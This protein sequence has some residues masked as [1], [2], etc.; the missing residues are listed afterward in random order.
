MRQLMFAVCV[1]VSGVIASA[2][3]DTPP[4]K[5]WVM[6]AQAALDW[7]KTYVNPILNRRVSDPQEIVAVRSRIELFIKLEESKILNYYPVPFYDPKDRTIQGY[8]F[9]LPAEKRFIIR[10]YIPVFQSLNK[11]LVKDAFENEVV[12]TFV[13]EMIHLEQRRNG[14]FTGAGAGTK[15]EAFAVGKTILQVVRPWLKQGK[16]LTREWVHA[17]GQLALVKDNYSDPRWILAL[18][19]DRKDE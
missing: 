17:S 3:Q 12:L 10:I 6:S 15:E 18:S 1:L 16:T 13:H 14:E 4:P 8:T 5:D 19:G 2:H 7:A 9:H 11:Q